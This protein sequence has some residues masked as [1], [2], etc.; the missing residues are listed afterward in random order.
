MSE[1]VDKIKDIFIKLD[2]WLNDNHLK[3]FII[4]FALGMVIRLLSLWAFIALG[5]D[6]WNDMN[7][8]V[9]IALNYLLSGIN[10]YGQSYTM[11]ILDVSTVENYYQYPPL[12]FLIH[13]PTL[14]WPGPSSYFA[15]DFQ[16]AYFIIH[17]VMDF[18]IFYRIWKVRWYGSAIGLW[19]I[20]GP[21]MVLFDFI[22][23]IIIPMMFLVLAYLN[24][25]NVKKSA[26]YIG[27]GIATYTYLAIPALFFLIYHYKKKK[28]NGIKN[29][30]IGLIPT[31]I[32][33]IPFIILGPSTF[34]N[35]LFLSQGTRVSG[36]F[37]HP[38]YGESYWWTHL[39]SIPPYANTI[40]NLI[41]NPGISLA[42]PYLTT[43]LLGIVLL[44]TMFYLYKLYKNNSK[45]KLIDYS[46]LMMLAVT[47]VAPSGFMGYIFLPVTIL[48]FKVNKQNSTSNNKLE[49][50]NE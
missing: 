2:K 47:L 33:L 17:F 18:Y 48:I 12:S 7:E 30:I 13:L 25:N 37:I 8:K 43:I 44:L 16:P 46:F 27:F 11:P 20:A 35:D 42:I 6:D 23:F 26:L 3:S 32:I 36:N 19:V 40:Y 14:L 29:F 34:V 38:T 4:I 10:P 15:V 21:L 22:T 50:F 5:T 49:K 28:L 1:L 39:F 31:F 9:W 45:S 41:V 24:I